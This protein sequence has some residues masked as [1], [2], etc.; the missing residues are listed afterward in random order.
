MSQVPKPKLSDQLDSETTPQQKFE[1][2]QGAL[3]CV[4]RVSKSD[5][6]QMLEQERQSKI[7]KQKPGP[8]PKTSASGREVSGK[9]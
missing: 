4:G 9:H 1:R 5:L 2:F 3:R 6:N 7:G 8:K